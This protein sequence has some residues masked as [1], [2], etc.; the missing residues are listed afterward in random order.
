MYKQLTGDTKMSILRPCPSHAYIYRCVEFLKMYI[1][2]IIY[3]LCNT[4]IKPINP[5]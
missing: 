5:I 3:K 2:D 1:K 4:L